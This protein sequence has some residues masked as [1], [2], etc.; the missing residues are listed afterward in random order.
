[1]FK[2][3]LPNPSEMSI[4]EFFSQMKIV[5]KAAEK[6]YEDMIKEIELNEENTPYISYRQPSL[7]LQLLED[8]KPEIMKKV[9]DLDEYLD[10]ANE[11]QL[12]INTI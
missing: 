4:P 12:E 9:I 11:I 7:R 6:S 1:M 8:T 3:N 2:I 10:E 5:L